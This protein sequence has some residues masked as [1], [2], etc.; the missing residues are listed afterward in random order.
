MLDRL[1][2]L[3]SFSLLILTACSPTISR[4]TSDDEED[5]KPIVIP[6]VQNRLRYA[7]T[8]DP[9]QK[10]ALD[11]SISALHLNTISTE[12]E[13]LQAIMKIR[14]FK[15]ETLQAWIETRVQYIVGGDYDD[16]KSRYK[17][18][19]PNFR[20]PSPGVIPDAD[21]D[22][23]SNT[24]TEKDVVMANIGAG[25]YLDGKQASQLFALD[26]PGI[27]VIPM[28]SPRIGVLQIGPGLFP[29]GTIGAGNIAIA[30]FRVGTLF[31]EAR[32]SD[33]NAKSLAFAHAK[34][35]Y[36]H[37]YQGR[38]ACDYP[39]NGAYT[40]GALMIKA[41]KDSCTACT[42]RQHRGLDAIYL[43]QANRVISGFV[44]IPSHRPASFKALPKDWDDTPEGGR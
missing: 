18:N 14:D 34:C 36:D 39:S 42:R 33:G 30:L 12:D 8:V 44:Y 31:H 37:D 29:N 38:D 4:D 23:V 28:I 6:P 11:E 3:F 43:D 17:L 9:L 10:A 22:G 7:S 16:Q 21:T 5:A 20:Y 25:V 15:P 1:V 41:L 35:P 13:R 27:G 32:H 26:I 2:L 19:R 40:V 24:E